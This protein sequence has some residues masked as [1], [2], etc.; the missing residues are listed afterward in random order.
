MELFNRDDRPPQGP[1]P[2]KL[3]RVGKGQTFV[4]TVLSTSL[5][6]VWTHWDGGRSLPCMKAKDKCLGCQRGFPKRWKGYLHCYY[7][8]A[9]ADF[10]L[11]LTPRA[12]KMLLEGVE[13][14]RML[15][16]LQIRME[17]SAGG[18]N[19]RLLCSVVGVD[20]NEKN[21]P[22]PKDPCDTLFFLWG[23]PPLDEGQAQRLA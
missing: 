19:G 12:S 14:G 2:L 7:A 17:R 5:F 13:E 23:L 20:L 16:G 1:K 10:L 6:G 15:R 22:S 18:R 3:I 11:E 21:L 8:L 4:Y 9:K